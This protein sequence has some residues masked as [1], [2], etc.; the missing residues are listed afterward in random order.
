MTQCNKDFSIDTT[1][2]YKAEVNLA[3]VDFSCDYEKSIML[4][5][6]LKS[7]LKLRFL[8]SLFG[9]NKILFCFLYTANVGMF[10][11][12]ANPTKIRP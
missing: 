3:R 11:K 10:L 2:N 9:I 1:Q 5:K 7:C 12:L 8:Y 6:K 4:C